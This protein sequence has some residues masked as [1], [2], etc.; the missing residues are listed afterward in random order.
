VI[1]AF[2]AGGPFFTLKKLHCVYFEGKKM[3]EFENL[4]NGMGGYS[5]DFWE[6]IMI[7]SILTVLSL[8]I[9][10]NLYA[11]ENFQ[12]NFSMNDV[13]ADLNRLTSYCLPQEGRDPTK[14]KLFA[15]MEEGVLKLSDQ[16]SYLD[17]RQVW[18]LKQSLSHC[19][20]S[21]LEV[22]RRCYRA[23]VAATLSNVGFA[24]LLDTIQEI[25][26][27]QDWGMIMGTRVVNAYLGHLF[28]EEEER[29][30]PWVFHYKTRAEMADFGCDR[31]RFNQTMQQSCYQRSYADLKRA[32]TINMQ[33][34]MVNVCERVPKKE[35]LPCLHT[36]ARSLMERVSA[37]DKKALER[38]YK[39]CGAAISGPSTI[40]G[41]LFGPGRR[42]RRAIACI[43]NFLLNK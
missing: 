41:G 18:F 13:E 23:V 33:Q 12:F 3:V 2:L 43:K 8:L 20:S 9:S 37:V 4:K 32:H 30:N 21:K 6:E 29:S 1:G 22:S 14:P 36:V 39:S 10:I 19:T 5:F 40:G 28:S 42:E 25:T 15:C 24:E 7:R 31:A 16:N 17:D 34:F 26:G 35:E 38:G 11:A 27:D